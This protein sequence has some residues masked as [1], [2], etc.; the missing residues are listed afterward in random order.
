MTWWLIGGTLQQSV[1]EI[2]FRHQS[3]ISDIKILKKTYMESES[4]RGSML[5]ETT[6]PGQAP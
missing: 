5:T 3:L 4:V 1:Y 2:V 6:H